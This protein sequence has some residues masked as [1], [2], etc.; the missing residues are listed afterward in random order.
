MAAIYFL[1]G[2]NLIDDNFAA[3]VLSVDLENPLFS[4]QRCALLKLVPNEYKPNWQQAFINNLN[5]SG[6]SSA[7]ELAWNLETKQ[8]RNFYEQKALDYFR[9]IEHAFST[10]TDAFLIFKS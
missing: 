9:Y 1:F 3:A 6:Q 8:S 7:S 4:D 2:D 10:E 5:A